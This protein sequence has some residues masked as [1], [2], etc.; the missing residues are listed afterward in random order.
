MTL[1]TFTPGI[2][3]ILQDNGHAQYVSTVGLAQPSKMARN[4]SGFVVG[5]ADDHTSEPMREELG[6][7]AQVP[8]W[9]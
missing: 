1:S 8:G 7:Y 5:Q 6:S 3:E 9:I 4:P 2:V